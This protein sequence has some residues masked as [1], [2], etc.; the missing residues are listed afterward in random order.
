MRCEIRRLCVL[1]TEQE[2]FGTLKDSQSSQ[3]S[4]YEKEL[5]KAKKEA[6]KSSS[7]ILKLQEELKAT[8]NSMRIAQSGWDVEKQKVE[9]KEQERFEMEYKLIPLQEQVEKLTQKLRIVESEKE[10]LKTNLQGEE[11]ARIAA[12]GM[13]ALPASQDMDID[14]LSSPQKRMM[15]PLSDDKEN[16]H[17]ISKKSIESRRL[18]E[19]LEREKRKREQAEEMAE[20]LRME[21]LFR[22]CSCRSTSAANVGHELS[23]CLDA[24]LAAGIEKIRQ[25]ME[26]ILTPAGSLLK[27]DEMEVE[28]QIQT[29][30]MIEG[31]VEIKSEVATEGSVV[32]HALEPVLED[33]LDRSM[34]MT[35]EEPGMEPS[36]DDQ[37]QEEAE[38]ALEADTPVQDLKTLTTETK[39]TVPIEASSPATPSYQGHQT[40]PFRQQPS[41][42]TVTT[43]TTVPMHF[44]PV[45]KPQL[46]SKPNDPENIENQP[47]SFQQNENESAV[48]VT[49]SFDR[50][51]ALAAI[52]YRR[53]RAKSIANGHATPQKQMMEGVKERRDI[54]APALG[55][56]GGESVGRMTTRSGSTGRRR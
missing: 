37:L 47:P 5:R 45:A 18:A 34:T 3:G 42:R 40:T 13:I 21:C 56:R 6:F 7:T 12:E 4:I 29:E 44:T 41:I 19:E 9:R 51:A 36:P 53:G 2:D 38:K 24:E 49:P 17:V 27:Q 16:M 50:A 39:L 54:S 1:T 55:Q 14:L 28:R 52:E 20:F 8:R 46:F 15:S 48:P 23:K 10:A 33:D 32:I 31:T 30:T 26:E 35:A 11:V 22:C 25:G 43:T